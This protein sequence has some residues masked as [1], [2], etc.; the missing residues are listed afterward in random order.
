MILLDINYL[1]LGYLP[2][3]LLYHGIRGF[4]MKIT[5]KKMNRLVL[6]KVEGSLV[7]EQL[8]QLEKEI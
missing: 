2:I 8:K 1:I 4:A 5:S 6:I 3:L 7:T